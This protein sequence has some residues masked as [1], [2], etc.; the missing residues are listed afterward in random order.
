MVIQRITDLLHQRQHQRIALLIAQYAIG[1][2]QGFNADHHQP[3][4]LFRAAHELLD[5]RQK[6][7]TV[8]QIGHGKMGGQPAHLIMYRLQHLLIAVVAA[9]QHADFIIAVAL[10]Q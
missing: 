6:Q 10:R 8:G 2:L 5:Q 9:D 7:G 3:Q 1:F 4:R